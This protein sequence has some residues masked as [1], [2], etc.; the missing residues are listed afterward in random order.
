MLKTSTRGNNCL[1]NI[2]YPA[3]F[4]DNA[5]THLQWIKLP[6]QFYGGKGRRVKVAGNEVHMPS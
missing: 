2:A 1:D 3:V 6:I 5:M 4:M